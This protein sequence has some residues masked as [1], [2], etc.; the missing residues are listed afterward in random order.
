MAESMI[1]NNIRLF[2]IFLC[3]I[4]SCPKV[5]FD[6]PGTHFPPKLDLSEVHFEQ[7]QRGFSL[8]ED[9]DYALGGLGALVMA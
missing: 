8:G 9:L 7:R 3:N 4:M 6:H 1:P 2:P 5:N